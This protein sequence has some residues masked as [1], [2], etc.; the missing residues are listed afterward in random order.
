MEQF[1]RS[2]VRAVACVAGYTIYEPEVD[3]DSVDMGIAG[4]SFDGLPRPPRIEIQLK[5]TAGNIIRGDKIAFVLRRKNYDELRLTH[6]NIVVPR[7]LVV[8]HIPEAEEEWLRQT[9]DELS[10]RKCG[11]WV[12]L[13]GRPETS[14]RASVT[15]D[16]PRSN[17]FDVE[18]LRGLMGRASR[19]EP[20]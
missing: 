12:S 19:K 2:Y 10:L 5:C 4:R 20:L 1:S 11:Y 3:D 8:V 18:H 16:L 9:E 14:N 13:S 6:E 17:R 7:L 15:V